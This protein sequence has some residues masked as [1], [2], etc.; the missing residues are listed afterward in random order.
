MPLEKN[1][2][3]QAF[4]LLN[5]SVLE[6]K[7]LI[8]ASASSVLIIQNGVIV[9][10]WYSGYHENTVNSRLVDGAIMV[11]YCINS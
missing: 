4:A 8:S 11:Q 10:E 9:N 5:E 6:T 7:N 1:I 2:N 3:E